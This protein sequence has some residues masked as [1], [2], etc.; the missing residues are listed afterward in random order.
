M[1]EENAK[2]P[3]TAEHVVA[4]FTVEGMDSVPR[5]EKV[6]AALTEAPGVKSVDIADG[7]ATVFYDPTRNSKEKLRERI[8]RAGY[9]IKDATVE[10][11]SPLT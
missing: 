4:E 8:E 10:R 6:R 11:D 3:G 9:K 2:A 5:E 7:K 1:S